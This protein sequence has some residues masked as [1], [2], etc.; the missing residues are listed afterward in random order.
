[1]AWIGRPVHANTARALIVIG[2]KAADP[3]DD[4]LDLEWPLPGRELRAETDESE[5][6]WLALAVPG[7]PAPKRDLD[8]HARLEPIDVRALEQADLDESHGSGRIAPR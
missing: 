6:P 4:R 8:L 1:M 5:P 3:R 2:A 7:S